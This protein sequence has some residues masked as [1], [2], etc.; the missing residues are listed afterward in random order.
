MSWNDGHVTLSLT[1]KAGP[2]AGLTSVSCSCEWA[3][4][5]P[6]QVGAKRGERA[7]LKLNGIHA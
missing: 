7:H 3:R 1:L 5:Y 2:K 6:T 4:M